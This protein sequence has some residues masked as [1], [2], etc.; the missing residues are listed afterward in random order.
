MGVAILEDRKTVMD[1]M[2]DVEVRVEPRPLELV[3]VNSKGQVGAEYDFNRNRHR[4]YPWICYWYPGMGTDWLRGRRFS[5]VT[6]DKL[7]LQR[8]P[9]EAITMLRIN[10]ETVLKGVWLEV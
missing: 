5:R 2:L 8:M 6:A 7:A 3:I 9:Q 10:T 4:Q 1:T